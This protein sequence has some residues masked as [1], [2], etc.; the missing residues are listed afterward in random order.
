M[1]LTSTPGFER[2]YH[3]AVRRNPYLQKRIDDVLRLL[4]LDFRTPALR[5]HKL[6]GTLAGLWACS[7][8][9]DCRIVFLIESDPRSGEDVVVL[10]DIGTHDE[11]Y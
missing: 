2:S 7:C 6:S 3:K 4:E 8:G 5:S 1:R 11:V 9:H 10:L